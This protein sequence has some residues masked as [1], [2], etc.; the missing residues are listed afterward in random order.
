MFGKT[1]RYLTIGRI[2][3]K[4]NLFTLLYKD[5]HHNHI[6]NR[7]CTCAFD[8]KKRENARKLR[9]AFEELGPSFVK[10]G[11]LLSKRSDLLPQTHI[12]ELENLQDHVK[13]L[14]F[15]RLYSEYREM[16]RRE[17]VQV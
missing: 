8:M 2:F 7:E 4:Y 15:D 3:F 13:T 11:Q 6:S 12:K 17:L 5:F 9:M 14:D 16:L 1:K 10:L